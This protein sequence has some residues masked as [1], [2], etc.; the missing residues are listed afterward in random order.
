MSDPIREEAGELVGEIHAF[1]E[2]EKR[3]EFQTHRDVY[4]AAFEL[5][6]RLSSMGIKVEE[7]GLSKE[8]VDDFKTKVRLFTAV[9]PQGSGY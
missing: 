4:R 8:E 3:G 6:E 2:K 9:E 7:L 5:Q 1:F